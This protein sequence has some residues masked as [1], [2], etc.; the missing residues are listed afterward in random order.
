MLL[1]WSFCGSLLRGGEGGVGQ[2][3]IF[4]SLASSDI[5]VQEAENTQAC[6]GGPEEP[7]LAQYARLTFGCLGPQIRVIYWGKGKKI[8]SNPP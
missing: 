2:I 6:S 5:T 7:K 8:P 3:F 4:F 1:N